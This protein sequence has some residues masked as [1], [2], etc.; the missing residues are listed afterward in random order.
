MPNVLIVNTPGPQGSTGPQGPPGTGGFDTGSLLT[1]AS[2][3]LN[4]ITFTKGDSSTFP[5]IV[6]TGS[7]GSTFPYTGSANISGSL[8]VTGSVI[9]QP[10]TLPTA[11]GTASMDCS[12]SNFFNLTLSGSYTLFLSASNMQPGQTINLRVI[13]P[14]IS[15]NLNYGSQFKFAGGIPYSASAS[16][17]VVDI[18]SFI[19]Y[20]TTTL[21]GSAIKNLS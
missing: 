5:I 17:S 8:K 6:N 14:A 10:I 19:S 18:I 13:Q 9:N 7:G 2:V 16:G 4:I 20:D 15:G 12:R 21:F 3:N 11:S 1:T